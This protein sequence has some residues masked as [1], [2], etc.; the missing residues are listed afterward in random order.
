MDWIRDRTH[1]VDIFKAVQNGYEHKPVF[2]RILEAPSQF[3]NFEKMNNLLYLKEKGYQLL[4]IPAEM[5]INGRSLRE[6]FI[7][8]VH[9]LL[10]HLSSV[11]TLAYLRDHV[12]WKSISEDVR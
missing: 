1:Y 11:K 2:K 12:W 3:K 10:A 4:C 8:E 7:S 5:I 9:S 6:I